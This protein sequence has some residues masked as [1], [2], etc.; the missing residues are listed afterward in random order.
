MDSRDTDDFYAKR[1]ASNPSSDPYR[2][3]GLLLVLCLILIATMFGV[4][5][6]EVIKGLY[7]C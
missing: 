2:D 4:M 7:L 3:T 6:Y 1:Q 5:M